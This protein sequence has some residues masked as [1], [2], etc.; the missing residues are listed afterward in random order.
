MMKKQWF[1]LAFLV[2]PILAC[3]PLASVQ[4]TPTPTKTPRPIKTLPPPPSP[5][6]PVI[7]QATD[8][9]TPTPVPVDTPTPIPPTDT[10]TPELPPTDTPTPPP[11]PTNTPVPPPPP[12]DT[13]IPPPTAPPPPT[14]PPPPPDSSPVVIIDLPDGDTY[15]E[16]DK[17]KFTITVIDPDGVKSFAW[18]VFAQNKSPVG[19]GGDKGCGGT[20]CS[21]SGDFRAKLP[22][23][24]FIGVDALDNNGNTKREIKQIYIG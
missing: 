23:Q 2:L 18:G 24:F 1:L 19:I 13:P 10:P 16:D 4:V 15:G 6:Q 11:P 7:V 12:T 20:E 8:T 21:L 17:V 3:G 14:E 5:T 22:G 9:P